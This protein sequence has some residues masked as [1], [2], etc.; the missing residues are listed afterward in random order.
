[1]GTLSGDEGL[2]EAI[3]GDDGCGDGEQP[4]KLAGPRE[5]HYA[6]SFGGVDAHFFQCG[7]A[8]RADVCQMP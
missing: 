7:L 2:G 3:K 5:R 4:V 1:M 6:A 8:A